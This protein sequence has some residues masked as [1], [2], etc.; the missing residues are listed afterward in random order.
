VWRRRGSVSLHCKRKTERSVGVMGR[1]CWVACSGRGFAPTPPG[2]KFIC[3]VWRG[4]KYQRPANL[5][6]PHRFF[7]Q[8][9]PVDSGQLDRDA[10]ERAPVLRAFAKGAVPKSNAMPG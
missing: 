5:C 2:G 4:N 9:G 8:T 6:A 3:F 1:E 7:E 10:A